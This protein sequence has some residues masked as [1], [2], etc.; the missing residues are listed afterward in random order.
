[1][2]LDFS[3]LKSL[4]IDGV[5]LNKLYISQHTNLVPHS[6]DTDGSLYNRC[7][8]INGYRLNSTG[9]LQKAPTTVTSGFI[10][11]IATSVI[12]LAGI[13]WLVSGVYQYLTYFDKNFNMLA[14]INYDGEMHVFGN[15]TIDINKSNI[16]SSSDCT[17]FKIAFTEG[18]DVSNIAYFRISGIGYGSNM[19]VTVDQ[20]IGSEVYIWKKYPYINLVQKSIDTN[21]NIYN[22]IGY[23]EG[24]RLSSGGTLKPQDGAV[25]TGFIPFKYGDKARMSNATWGTSVKTG[26]SYIIFYDNNFSIIASVNKYENSSKDNHISNASSSIVDIPSSSIITDANGVTTFN[27]SFKQQYDIAYIR[28][29]AT[30]QGAD[31]IVT[32]NEEIT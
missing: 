21:G 29:S 2:N 9:E 7:G 14:A 25:A 6:I 10:P 8:Y 17:T 28:I 27:I 3:K 30:G 5:E 23:E 18:A 13:G 22:N 16:E 19:T 4:N 32:V 24:Y 31:M 20:E 11:C 26:Y 1:M 15:V 12:R